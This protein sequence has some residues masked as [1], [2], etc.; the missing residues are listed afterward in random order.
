MA[1]ATEQKTPGLPLPEILPL[2]LVWG[3]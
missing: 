3:F 1:A 2:S